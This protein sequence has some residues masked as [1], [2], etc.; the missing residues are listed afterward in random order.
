MRTI[1]DVNYIDLLKLLNEEKVKFVLVGG[2]AV[3]VHGIYRT[4]KDMD[5]LYEGKIEN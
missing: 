1:F 3:V 2:L 4:T 5:I